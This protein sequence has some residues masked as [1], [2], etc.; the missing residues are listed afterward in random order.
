MARSQ[1][2]GADHVNRR[3]GL[4]AV[5]AVIFLLAVF[6]PLFTLR[7]GS[8]ARPDPSH[9]GPDSYE[10]LM[11]SRR[12][13][14]PRGLPADEKTAL[15]ELGG[16]AVAEGRYHVHA[17]VQLDMIPTQSQRESLAT[18]G[19]V[20]VEYIPNCAWIA[21]IPAGDP[22]AAVK[23]PG[24]RWI[25]QPAL[26]DKT[27]PALTIEAGPWA[28][29]VVTEKPLSTWS[30]TGMCRTRLAGRSSQATAKW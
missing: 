4:A 30:C 22:A 6:L 1:V 2:P 29:D 8:G 13:I 17:L 14:P 18:R 11:V 5:S 28:Y 27:D 21:A 7:A 20:L 9:V 25:G 16:S 12:F 26:Q 10:I 3:L 15:E 24:V 23:L 19:L